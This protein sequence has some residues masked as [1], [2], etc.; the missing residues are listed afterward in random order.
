VESTTQSRLSTAKRIAVV[1]SPGAG[2]STLAIQLG[3]LLD[4]PVVHLDQL[5]WRPGWIEAG[6]EAFDAELE[7]VVGTDA[8]II[9]GNYSRTLNVRLARADAAVMLDFPRK[10]CIYRSLKR[11][12]LYRGVARPDMAPGCPEKVDLEF[13]RFI[14]GYPTRSRLRVLQKLRAFGETH[15]FGHIDGT[16]AVADLLASLASSRDA[17]ADAVNTR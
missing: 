7:R 17:R 8:W 16:R 2:K 14:W 11:A 15:T 13:L 1:G 4:L 12:I 5:W 10:L 9:D 3:A 6:V